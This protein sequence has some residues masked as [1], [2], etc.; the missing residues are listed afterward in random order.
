MSP[1]T[2]LPAPESP[3]QTYSPRQAI[4]RPPTPYQF[5]GQRPNSESDS[6]ENG[7]QSSRIPHDI[8]SNHATP[9]ST[10]IRVARRTTSSGISNPVN[11]E[12]QQSTPTTI[13]YAFPNPFI[14]T[15]SL[16]A[17][18]ALNPDHRYVR[19]RNSGQ[20]GKMSRSSRAGTPS[21][22]FSAGGSGDAG[23]R[24]RSLMS[25]A[26]DVS[27]A[28]SDRRIR[29]RLAD[30]A[31]VIP[32]PSSPNAQNQQ[33]RGNHR[34][35]PLHREY[36]AGKL[37]PAL[38][39]VQAAMDPMNQREGN[40][41]FGSGVETMQIESEM[42]IRLSD[43]MRRAKP[44]P[45]RP[46]PTA[47]ATETS[48]D[49][50]AR[51]HSR[52]FSLQSLRQSLPFI[53]SAMHSSPSGHPRRP[54]QLGA[55][56]A[57]TRLEIVAPS[58]DALS[59]P[60]PPSRLPFVSSSASR[61]VGTIQSPR[62]TQPPGTARQRTQTAALKDPADNL[63]IYLRLAHLPKWTRWIDPDRH[64]QS[65]W[66]NTSNWGTGR[67]HHGSKDP[68]LPSVASEAT[69]RRSGM[70]SSHSIGEMSGRARTIDRLVQSV[71]TNQMCS[72]ADSGSRD[73]GHPERHVQ[74]LPS[75]SS[76]LTANIQNL[77]PEKRESPA[78]QPAGGARRFLKSWEVRR[79]FLDGIE[80]CKFLFSSVRFPAGTSIVSE[81]LRH[82]DVSVPEDIAEDIP[83]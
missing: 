34:S 72:I 67:A 37:R 46:P 68:T 47:I 58:I 38:R 59:T 71:V 77:D 31:I 82:R 76:S 20:Q 3:P 62:L 66:H 17:R 35:Q 13:E 43:A 5:P 11:S 9:L 40:K 41:D 63:N 25:N 16:R 22:P 80:N 30:N 75:S 48:G 74:S 51:G 27:V 65:R 70:V 8:I 6:T 52:T 57:D 24:P 23:S 26:E 53:G 81:A 10:E 15:A 61:S 18:R 73:D 19:R 2:Q 14:A 64:I 79:G 29:Q 83:C 69:D 45:P 28:D 21:S 33:Q 42:D 7:F 60:P 50:E 36:S 12:T 44:L 39:V 1:N 4:R 32:S 56:G 49:I 54:S 78:D 55:S